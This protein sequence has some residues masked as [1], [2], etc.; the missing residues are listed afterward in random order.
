[1]AQRQERIDGTA[2]RFLFEDRFEGGHPAPSRLPFDVTSAH[3]STYTVDYLSS[4]ST[5][6]FGAPY[7]L[8]SRRGIL[9]VSGERPYE[10][11]SAQAPHTYRNGSSS[12]P[13]RR[14]FATGC[15]GAH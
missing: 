7:V 11:T 13:R 12:V 1:M 8:P 10:V 14:N 4:Y 15:F 9:Y 3:E 5:F 6:I 2:A